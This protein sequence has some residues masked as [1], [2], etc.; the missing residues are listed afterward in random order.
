METAKESKQN[1]WGLRTV[2]QAG[3]LVILAA[4]IGLGVNQVRSDRLPLVGD[5]SQEARLK[6]PSGQG[7]IITLEEAEALFLSG[8]AIFL[9]AR[10]STEYEQGHIESALCLPW[11]EFNVFF[12][13]VMHNL[14][15][16]ATLIT[17]CDGETCDLS[18][19]LAEELYNMG[20]EN[21]RVLVNGWSVWQ[22]AG[23]PV[24]RG[25]EE[26]AAGNGDY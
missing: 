15:P 14:F 2:W 13:H 10:S 1:F 12:D 24:G 6:T 19:H 9:D 3:G 4:V 23:L 20:Y 26:P 18:K 21:V 11:Q 8:Q 7:M 22:K 25:L 5:W 16:G 17:Y